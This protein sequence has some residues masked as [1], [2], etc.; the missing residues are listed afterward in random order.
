[1]TDVLCLMSGR[2]D[3]G[4]PE[5]FSPALWVL[6]P[7]AKGAAQSSQCHAEMLSMMDVSFASMLLSPTSSVRSRR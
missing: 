2:G 3:E 7:A 4:P 6:Q 5:T 1:M